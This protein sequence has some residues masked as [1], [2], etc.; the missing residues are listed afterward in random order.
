[1]T[2]Y[3]FKNIKKY[4][5]RYI[6]SGN[7]KNIYMS[8]NLLNK[9]SIRWNRSELCNN[10]RNNNMDNLFNDRI[11]SVQPMI[12][13]NVTILENG[14]IVT[15]E[16]I[17]YRTTLHEN[18]KNTDNLVLNNLHYNDVICLSGKWSGEI[19]HFPFEFLCKLRTIDHNSKY[20]HIKKNIYTEHWL[21]LCEI[22][23][24]YIISGNIYAIN[25]YV[26]HFP[27]CGDPDVSDI[28]WLKSIV[29]KKLTTN[30]Y[31]RL[32]LVKRNKSRCLKNYDELEKYIMI[33]AIKMNLDL[34]IHDDNHLPDLQTQLQ[35]F[36][37]AKIIITPHGGSEINLLACNK[38]THVIE[39][40][41]IEY[42][43]LCFTRI[44][45]F[46][47]LNYYALDTH[48]FEVNMSEFDSLLSKIIL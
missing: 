14:D 10:I 42:T 27:P 4:D 36:F 28:L 32:I 47:D 41:D 23:K 29:D 2:T 46:L 9:I 39:L 15:S 48:N 33:Y 31:T 5:I 3:I 8:N 25:A 13:N 38:N 24:K 7:N 45:Y 35:Y 22:D 26:P 17:M 43:N 12:L 16:N 20:I 6:Q 21:K 30:S 40:M 18:D 37:E 1:M 44:A 19:F 11:S 34:L